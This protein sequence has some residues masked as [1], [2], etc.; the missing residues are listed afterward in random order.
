VTTY[1]H[2]L[3]RLSHKSCE[4]Q[5]CGG[6]FGWRRWLLGPANVFSQIAVFFSKMAMVTFGGA[7]A[8]RAY[9]AQQAVETKGWLKPGEI[10]GLW[11]AEK[12]PGP[13]IMVLQFVGLIATYRD[14]TM[15][16]PMLAGTLEGL[17]ATWVTFTP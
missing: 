10:D 8:V 14:P 9:V 17:L 11:M 16:S 2:M 5:S 12:A 6:C 4:L 7:Y 1:P 13:L 3:D 15:L